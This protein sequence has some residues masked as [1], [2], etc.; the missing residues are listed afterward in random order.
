MTTSFDWVAIRILGA[1]LLARV[2]TSF[3]VDL[4]PRIVFDARTV[5]GIARTA[6]A[7]GRRPVTGSA[8]GRGP[9]RLPSPR[10]SGDCG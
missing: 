3:D 10:P 5:A 4:S 1:K 6:A 8:A 9:S 7:A 2:R